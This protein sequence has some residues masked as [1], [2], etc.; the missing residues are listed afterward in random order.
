MDP[1]YQEKKE[2]GQDDRGAWPL[3]HRV[4]D[5]L[6]LTRDL[7]FARRQPIPPVNLDP[8]EVYVYRPVITAGHRTGNGGGESRMVGRG[9]AVAD[10]KVA[11]RTIG[12]GGHTPL[13]Y[14]PSSNWPYPR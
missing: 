6:D 3:P 12:F 4:T 1:G 7:F 5:P 13:Y 2:E 9:E 10:L 14:N 8:S 11:K